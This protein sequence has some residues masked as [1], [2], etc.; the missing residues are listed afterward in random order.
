MTDTVRPSPDVLA[1]H[2]Q[3]ETVLLHMGSKR[4]F[5]LN[6]SGQRIWQLLESGVQPS[7]LAARIHEE[8]EIDTETARAGVAALLESLQALGLLENADQA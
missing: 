1:A 6:D 5:H 7:A 3:D 8:F 2:L 4:Y